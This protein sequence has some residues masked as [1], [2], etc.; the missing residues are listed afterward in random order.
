MASLTDCALALAPK[1]PVYASLAGL[2]NAGSE[3]L[4]ASLAASAGARLA[5]AVGGEGD[6]A[7]V[8]LAARW[9]A[10]LAGAG[11]VTP[12]S[13]VAALR[14][15]VDGASSALRSASAHPRTVQPWADALV[16]AA[17]AALPWGGV[18]LVTGAKAEVEG[19][20]AAA[21]GY[22]GARPRSTS[23]P[24]LSP[25]W[26]DLRPAPG[27]DAPPPPPPPPAIDGPPEASDSGAASYLTVLHAAVRAWWAGAAAVGDASGD[28][29]ALA[30]LLPS[31]PCPPAAAPGLVAGLA[32]GRPHALPAAPGLAIPA[33][34]PAAAACPPGS[35]PDA[36]AAAV[37]A[38]H[39]P[40][41]R[42]GL[43]PPATLGVAVTSGPGAALDLLI[44]ES[45]VAD[46][47]RAFDGD[48]VALARRLAH[49][50][51]LGPPAPDGGGA[52]AAGPGGD[53]QAAPLPPTATHSPRL[54]PLLAAC[55]FSQLLAAPAPELPPLAYGAAMVDLCKL[56]PA[57]PRAMSACVREA[58]ARLATPVDPVLGDRLAAWL[59]YHLSNFEF[60]WP[61]ARWAAVLEAP[62]HDPRRRFVGALLDRLMRLSYRARL[63]GVLPEG[64]GF[65]GALLPPEPVIAPAAAL[66]A[67]TDWASAP[68]AAARAAAAL[69]VAQLVRR[70]AGDEAM[71]AWAR[72]GGPG[73]SPAAAAVLAAAGADSSDPASGPAA[74]LATVLHGLL[75]AG[76]K[77]FTH[78]GTALERHGAVVRA[79]AGGVD[80]A[81]GAGGVVAVR[82]AVAAWE[83]SPARAAQAVDRLLAAG[84]VTPTD[85]VTWALSPPP[86][87]S[88]D[89]P[90]SALPSGTPPT[91]PF[92]ALGDGGAARAGCAGREVLANAATAPAATPGD[93]A[94]A[95]TLMRDALAA[96]PGGGAASGGGDSGGAADPAVTAWRV[97]ALAS[98][99]GFARAHYA[100]LAPVAEGLRAGALA[101]GVA[102]EDVRA[103]LLPALEL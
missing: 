29:A 78:L 68:P 92:F 48:R 59:A 14:A 42:V 97:H 88:P 34:P 37:L 4:G 36:L 79:L 54:E 11:V 64:D 35:S 71:L 33:L 58:F 75:V 94:L 26:P 9:V 61:W 23:A 6:R 15:L 49:G 12:A 85:A 13:A 102:P 96:G 22:A 50:L 16:G 91:P 7:G 65:V 21:E 2:L 90:G 40:A 66:P 63:V 62:P 46:T 81:G 84:L 56:L 100:A 39:P 41:G 43:L 10:A 86:A 45:Y 89:W 19:L 17:L 52:A 47:L 67:G 60:M 70:K 74:L 83:A 51:P 30:A 8:R 20:L 38:A 82:A 32:A 31:L 99:R 95:L 24:G 103:A 93:L 27:A 53:H 1:A 101:A 44:A 5:A 77:S 3:L 28:S 57:F 73:G 55:L 87:G 80:G 69:E 72:G 98:A 25:F 18:E 76:S